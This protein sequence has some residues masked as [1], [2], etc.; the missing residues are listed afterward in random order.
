MHSMGRISTYADN[1]MQ[2]NEYL[3]ANKMYN[4]FTHSLNLKKMG[5]LRLVI[6]IYSLK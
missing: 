5:V 4:I 1:E 2:N 6:Y 3:Q